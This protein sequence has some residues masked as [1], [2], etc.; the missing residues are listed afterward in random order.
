[1]IIPFIIRKKRD[2]ISFRLKSGDICYRCKSDIVDSSDPDFMVWNPQTGE[3][4]P[5]HHQ[6]RLCKSCERD[7]KLNVVIKNKKEN[8][9]FGTNK[10]FHIQTILLLSSVPFNGLSVVFRPLSIIGSIL[11]FIGMYFFYKNY[12]ATTRSKKVQS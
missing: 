7:I 5:G 2:S 8:I 3:V 6:Q 1:M 12:M 4:Y 11:L 9:I 10:S